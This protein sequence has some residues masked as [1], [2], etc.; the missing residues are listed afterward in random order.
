M[1]Q[2]A[3]AY[4]PVLSTTPSII[5]GYNFYVDAGNPISYSGTGSIWTDL[6][7]GANNI[8]LIGAPVYDSVDGGG[9]FAM[10]SSS[11]KYGTF[12]YSSDFNLSGTDSTLEVWVKFNSFS[13]GQ[14]VLS[15]DRNGAYFNWCVYVPNSTTIANY[16]QG[17]GANYSATTSLSTGTWYYI[18]ITNISNVA[19]IYLNSVELGTG[20]TLTIDNTVDTG[21]GQTVGCASF[22]LPNTGMDGKLSIA[23]VYKGLALSA[24]QV[25]Q[26]WNAQK[27][28]YGY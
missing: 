24:T 4:P 5:G 27:T 11:T 17:T 14:I 20:A 12:N 15:K 18:C 7:V 22:N 1:G 9:N 26:N 19:H 16:T 3:L 13:A 10:S 25:V 21:P 6:S 2:F 23:R 8:T 28:R